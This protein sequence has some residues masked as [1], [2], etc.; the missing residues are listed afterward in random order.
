MFSVMNEMSSKFRNFEKVYR[1]YSCEGKEIVKIS[2][3]NVLLS[4]LSRLHIHLY[5]KIDRSYG[6]KNRSE[7]ITPT[8]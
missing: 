1:N 2:N 5:S 7:L 4:K 8:S 6:S 3:L